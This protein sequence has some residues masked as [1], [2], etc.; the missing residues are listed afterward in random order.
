MF[1]S[2]GEGG[3]LV[4]GGFVL[5]SAEP[6]AIPDGAVR[7]VGDRIADVG[8]WVDLSERHPDDHVTGGPND[9]ITAGFVNTHG[10]FSEAL[11]TGIAEQHT[12]WEWIDAL[13]RPI[14][15]CLTEDM[16]YYG[17]L[18]GAAQMLRTGITVANDMFVCDPIEGPVTPGV[19]RALDE[20]GLRGVV[21]FGASDLG[22]ASTSRLI[23]EHHALRDAADASRLSSFR[24]GIGAVGGQTPEMLDRSVA[25]AL[26]CN[27]GIHIHLQE[28]REEVTESRREFGVTP[29][30]RCAHIG[31]FEAPTI[32]AHCVWVDAADRELLAA[33]EVGVAHNPVSNM[34]LASG[35][36]PVPDLRALGVA[37]GI[38]VDG[39]ASNDSQNYL[40]SIKAT[41]LMQRL[42]SLQATAMTAREA[43]KMA[44]IEGARSLGLDDQVGSLEVGKCADLVVFDGDAPALLNV[45]DPFQKIAYCAGPETVKDVWIA[46]ERPLMAGQLTKIDLADVLPRARELS[47]KL[48]SDAGLASLSLL[49]NGTPTT[50]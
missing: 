43:L 31:L 50:R 48:V 4:R 27:C 19:V 9:I 8:S 12:L 5:T 1:A 15:P 39:P 26:D 7:V 30:A 3:T 11:V 24:V 47:T 46:G 33:H 29:I 35:V 14:N 34:I 36:C 28:I 41:I 25:L 20:I 6:E 49:A 17:T 42:N 37:V 23:D 40:E 18:V 21:S 2:G 13:I 44:T 38:G 10:H 22:E 32:A 45:H 16:A